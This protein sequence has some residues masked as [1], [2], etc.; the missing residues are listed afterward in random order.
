MKASCLCFLL[1]S[2][3]SVS[4]ADDAEPTSV[5]FSTE[6]GSLRIKIGNVDVATYVYQDSKVPRPYFTRVRTLSGQEV[7]R[8]HPPREG[9]DKTDHEGL[10]PGIW[11]SFGDL[12]GN[13]Y[14]RLQAV[15][16][17]V[18][19][20]E[21][22]NGGPGSGRFTVRNRYLTAD[23]KQ[24]VCEEICR[25]T[26]AI[27][28]EGY[29]IDYSSEFLAADNELVFGDQEE[30][31]LGVRV[32][33]PL[34]V[35]TNLGGR[36]LDSAGRINGQQVWGETASWCDY[37]GN[38]SGKWAGLTV[39]TGPKNF[40]A[41]WS[42]ARDYGF[43]AMNPFGHQA[44]TKQPAEPISVSPGAKLM[45]NYSV[46]VHESS[47]ESE[48]APLRAY[49]TYAQSLESTESPATLKLKL[50]SQE[51]TSGKSVRY[52][53]LHRD[54]QWKPEQTALIVCDMWDLHHCFRAVE[55]VKELAPHLE[56][57]LQNARDRG[58]TIIHAPSSCMDSYVNHPSRQ[59]AIN[60]P[61]SHHF[62]PEINQWCYKI[63]AEEKGIYPI[64][65]SQGGE[66]DDPVEHEKW[67]AELT[68]IGRDPKVPWKSQ[69]ESLT[70][71]G[72]RD[73]ISDNGEEIW[74]ILEERGISNVILT[75]VHTNMCVLGRPF[76]LRRM[77]EA[78]KNTVL[79]SDMTDTMYDP[80]C[81]PFVS[82][83][84]GTDLIIDH[85]ERHVCPT[86]TS[87]QL[88]GGESF[89]F[90]EDR[91]PTIAILMAED[92]YQTEE[93]LPTWSIKHLGPKYR[94]RWIYGSDRQQ[95]SIPG[96][97]A[98]HDADLLL[99]SVRRRPIQPEQLDVI[100]AFAASG[101]PMLG[102][103]TA[104]HA[105]SLR[106]SEVPKGTAAWPKFDNEVW[107]GR[108]TNHHGN[109]FHP[110]ITP[111]AGK[112]KHPILKDWG[113]EPFVSKGSLYMVSPLIDGAI[114]ILEGAIGGQPKEPIAWTF[115]RKS[116]G[117]SFYTSL[118]HKED[119]ADPR[120][121]Q[122]LSNAVDWLLEDEK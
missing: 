93:S 43:V 97:D 37:S 44:F 48:Y 118:G 17:H 58:V 59:R 5:S 24:T 89:R 21:P 105:F 35:E 52:H 30:M 115:T 109:E 62:P 100:R 120:F 73:Y 104:S 67:A 76:G 6:N 70:I 117:R 28:P 55:R 68:K 86:I 39:L 9:I 7:T 108:Y 20:V 18:E 26:I 72:E 10:H 50:H 77:V 61:R 119:F 65:Q 101:K 103:R 79:M 81:S 98:I 95:E 83:F 111:V 69:Y 84:T 11:L 99:V 49:A 63:P 85:I 87:D 102:I 121:N 64:D 40:R 116:G 31:G 36:I 8:H 33:T 16:E 22:P 29:R 66:D 14:W 19:F 13:D 91:R 112:A 51:E 78:G 46:V 2:F 82:H 60:T 71:D 47:D 75:G 34:A 41:C 25:H 107:G 12:N 113:S 3:L 54:A 1:F 92:E 74:S 53:R 23:G 94:I 114:P 90:A 122:L 32:A 38:L 57:V 27:V 110:S 96:I 4:I 80:R 88:I 106:N 45:L 15:T 56:K 42:H